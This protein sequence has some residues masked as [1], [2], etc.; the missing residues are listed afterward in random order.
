MKSYSAGLLNDVVGSYDKTKTT[1]AGRVAQKTINSNS[2]L[3]PPLTKFID[4]YTDTL[5]TFIPGMMSYTSNGRLFVLQSVPASGIL[6]QIVCY[7]FN[8]TTGAYSYRGKIAFSIAAPATLSIRGFVVEDSDTNNIKI[9]IAYTSTQAITGGVIMSNKVALTDFAPVGF[10]TIYTALS[11][12][13]K[14]M[15]V[16]QLPREAGGLHLL[17]TVTGISLPNSS[18]DPNL[19]TKL[20]AHN[21]VAATHQMYVFDWSVAPTMDASQT[22]TA[23]TV[24][25]SPTFTMTAHGYLAND[26]LV[27]TAN[28]PTGFTV[29]GVSTIQTVYYVRAA[30]L[31]ANTFELSL[32]PGGVAINATSV[33]ASTVFV[34]AN[35]QTTSLGLGKT[36]NLP[37]LVGTLLLTNSEN[38]CLPSHT[39][40]SGFDCVFMATSSTL[41]L[42]RYA[43]LFSYRTGT[44]NG[45]INVTGMAS[46][47]GLS[48]GQTVF[49]AGIPA[50]TTI[51]SIVSPTAITLS[52]SATTSTT[53]TLTFGASL[54]PNLVNANVLGNGTDYLLPVPVNAVYSSVCD[55]AIFTSTGIYGY[56][57]KMVNSQLLGQIGVAGNT[58]LEAQSHVTDQFSLQTILGFEQRSGWLFASCITAPQ[59]GIVVMDISADAVFE[60]AYII[61]PVLDARDSVLKSIHTCEELFDY[62]SS[63]QVQYR[64]GSTATDAV[65]NSAT[66]GWI[67]VDTAV[68]LSGLSNLGFIQFRALFAMMSPPGSNGPS[69]TTPT[70]LVEVVYTVQKISESSENWDYDYDASSTAIPTRVG[71]KLTK[72]YLSGT[73]PKIHYRAY[74]ESGVLVT[75]HNSVDQASNFQYSTDQGATWLPLGTIPNTVG[76]KIRYTY[77]VPPGANIRVSIRES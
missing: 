40:N 59:R 11:S 54:W 57:K 24:A 76:T 69:I 70:Q 74:D 43:D 9:F 29:T 2:V 4:V 16:L 36:A 49:G 18:S 10:N 56:V 38:A 75:N 68:D 65:F 61:T 52:V 72:S 53:Q 34:R 13:T 27:M 35:G 73:V 66:S 22:T 60:Q 21:G 20:F 55:S 23:P 1:I 62:T 48:I 41:Y 26:P 14:G 25:A 51:A 31:T 67:S 7:D 77:S 63:L 32:T 6:S 44:T 58:Y 17:T 71:F 3:G 37:A 30:N 15:Y 5:G 50:S 28:A 45:T 64:T 19:A 42:G 8:N 39:L 33:T 46:T 47:T 12:D